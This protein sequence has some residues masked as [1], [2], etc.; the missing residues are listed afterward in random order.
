MRSL[1]YLIGG[2]P[3]SLADCV[4]F[5]GRLRPEKVI[6]NLETNHQIYGSRV[7]SH[8]VAEF[9]WQG[10]TRDRTCEMCLGRVRLNENEMRLRKAIDNVNRRLREVLEELDNM[11]LP[12]TAAARRFEYRCLDHAKRLL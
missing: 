4:D 11:Q 2:K 12:L 7:I 3:R 10:Q 5:A 6:L 1:T 9:V 8:F